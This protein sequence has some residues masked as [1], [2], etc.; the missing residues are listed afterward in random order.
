MISFL[1]NR[2]RHPRILFV[3][4]LL[5][6][7][8]A[9]FVWRF[10]PSTTYS[11]TAATLG[12]IS[13]D[14]E[15]SGV[16]RSNQTIELSWQAN[17]VVLDVDAKIGDRVKKDQVLSSLD[18]TTVDR[19]ILLAESDRL[20]AQDEYDRVSNPNLAI[21]EA[22][23]N[24]VTAKHDLDDAQD[25]YDALMAPRGSQELLDDLNDQIQTAKD[26]LAYLHQ[27]WMRFYDTDPQKDE[28]AGKQS[29]IL[30]IKQAEQKITDLIARYNWFNGHPD[31]DLVAQSQAKIDIAKHT[32]DDR[33]RIYE[34]VK[35]DGDLQNVSKAWGKLAAA[36]A[37][38]NKAKLITPI[39]GVITDLNLLPGDVVTPGKVS[40]RVD[41][42]SAFKLDLFI[43]E[44]D[45]HSVRIGQPVELNAKNIDGLQVNGK[46]VQIDLASR[47]VD[48]VVSYKVVVQFDEVDQRLKPGMSID[49]VIHL[50]QFQN[51]L[52]VPA[53]AIRF[54]NGERIV[55]ILVK[56]QP[57]PVK[58]RVGAMNGEQVQVVGG[59][60]KDGDKVILDPP[61]VQDIDPQLIQ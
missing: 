10:Y 24:F 32:M 51:A 59:N 15:A 21:A 23:N 53:S 17:G 36:T 22:W 61:S 56:N 2:L 34:R 7:T 50:E 25:E 41:D 14:I 35:Q 44:V 26:D 31:P 42:L 49:A 48:G 58:I 20:I 38:V 13:S 29:F 16:L 30:R 40:I 4:V 3:I 18:L 39:N 12:N 60:I 28:G 45:I 19:S 8:A 46:I 6:S 55:F 43:S 57:V 54:V 1:A 37:I 33:G 9:F 27:M 5:V 11:V 47:L 52:L